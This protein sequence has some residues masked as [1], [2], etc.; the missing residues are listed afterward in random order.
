[1]LD[2]HVDAFMFFCPDTATSWHS[3]CLSEFRIRPEHAGTRDRLPDKVP[4]HDTI[5]I[6]LDMLGTI[7]SMA[8]S[9][10]IQEP[11]P[12]TTGSGLCGSESRRSTTP[13][14]PA[15]IGARTVS[16]RRH[17]PSRRTG[18]DA[19]T[20]CRVSSQDCANWAWPFWVL[21]LTLDSLSRSA[22]LAV[23]KR[24]GRSSQQS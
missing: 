7:L 8:R 20:K 4:Q 2:P 3:G 10:L 19:C 15:N 17:L 22:T 12:V 9:W 1:M 6:K 5:Q 14:A 24:S 11:Q 23:P 13:H 21:A 16:R 18:L